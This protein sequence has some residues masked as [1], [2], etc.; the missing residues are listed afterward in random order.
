VSAF[1]LD[2]RWGLDQGFD[3]YIDDF[4][5]GA[6]KAILFSDVQK[7]A[8]HVVDDALAWLDAKP[9]GP[10]FLWVHLYDPHAPYDPPEPYARRF[11]NDPYAGEIAFMDAQ[12]GRLLDHLDETGERTRSFIVVAGD[13]GESLGEH[14][15]N[16][17]GFFTYEAATRV[18]LIF[19]TPFA[20]LQGRSLTPLFSDAPPVAGMIAYVETLYPRFHY[21]WS[22]LTS[23]QDDRLK[24]IM[25]SD[26]EL[27]DLVDDPGETVNLAAERPDDIDR[28]TAIAVQLLATAGAPG[29]Q[30]IAFE[31][32]GE[33]YTALGRLDD[34]A[35]ACRRVVPL[36]PNWAYSYTNLAEAQIAL[37][38]IEAAEQTLL[39][40]FDLAE[41]VS[42]TYCLLGYFNEIR[43]DLRGAIDDYEACLDLDPRSAGA[44]ARLAMLRLQSN[45]LDIAEAHAL[46]AIA[47]DP[48][49]ADANLALARLHMMR[50][51]TEPARSYYQ[52]ELRGNPDNLL[53]HF[54]LAVLYRQEGRV[55]EEELHLVRV[56]EIDPTH[57]RA[58]LFLARLYVDNNKSYQ[59]G[60][61][62]LS[63][64][65]Q[66]PMSSADLVASYEILAELHQRLGNSALAREFR[67]KARDLRSP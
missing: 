38:Q 33:I 12:I 60:V 11:A 15:E 17:H 4:G 8:D 45:E 54:D 67:Q 5:A 16:E 50:D 40:S 61:D 48:A 66:G 35:A 13:H 56:L 37:G 58:A 25:S 3:T 19:W 20:G 47:I 34:A 53:A 42:H 10:F 46:A 43:A 57:S 28:L 62:V 39:D 9:D 24:L 21:G 30:T 27:Y 14:G 18:P 64:A 22:E 51:E 59:Q 63:A 44:L 36:K 55:A 29:S 7:R 65:V 1:V 49:V 32:L 52:D 2:S 26:P 41:P 6:E 23:V 31:R